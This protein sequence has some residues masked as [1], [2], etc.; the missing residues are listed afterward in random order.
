MELSLLLMQQICQLFIMIFLGFML[1]KTKT[2]N[3][4]DSKVISKVILFVV[5]P[6][7][8][9][10]SFM[11]EFTPD[12]LFGLGLAL[13]GAIIVHIIYI[14]LTELLGKIFGFAPIEKATII[15]S[16]SGN[17][18]IPLVGAILG[19]E[20]VLYT[21][22]Y[23]IVQTI[24]LWTHAKSLVCN[25]KQYDIKKIFLNVNVIAIMIGILLFLSQFQ[26]PA[27]V[28]TTFDKVGSM[29]GPLAMIVI[30]MLIGEM[31]FKDIFSEKRTYLICLMR[32]I[33]Y[34]LITVLV[35]RLTGLSTI[36]SDANQIFLIT[37]LAASAPAAAT[38]TQFAQLYN[39]HPGYASI[40]NVMSVI[41]SIISMPLM[42]MLYQLL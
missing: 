28:V 22:G 29:I 8:I 3:T 16:N 27:L 25:E 1:V 41:F 15:Y 17:L 21:S 26:L 39:K 11:I 14:P 6:C 37:I 5:S 7:A 12:K 19:K 42:V 31:N 13:L 32:L 38:I 4:Q 36:S 30:G 20:W 33:V 23:M 10:T 34:P 9:L 2:L 18:I 35:F 24:L 40:M